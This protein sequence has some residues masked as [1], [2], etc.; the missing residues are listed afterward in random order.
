MISGE[1]GRAQ[2]VGGALPP[3]EVQLDGLDPVRGT[4]RESLLVDLRPGDALGVSVQHRRP[5]AQGSED[6]V[7]DGEVVLREVELGDADLGEVDPVGGGD[8]HVTAADV[9][10]DVLTVLPGGHLGRDPVATRAVAGV[11]VD[12][13]RALDDRP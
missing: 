6:A 7:A 1:L 11:L 8:P 3:G 4:L 10:M 2:F 13:A 9:E 5:L 12:P